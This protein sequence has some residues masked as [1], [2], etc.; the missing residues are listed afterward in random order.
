M[1]GFIDTLSIPI[2]HTDDAAIETFIKAFYQN[3]IS[4]P[5]TTPAPCP[6][7]SFSRRLGQL[8]GQVT[9]STARSFQVP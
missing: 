9:C 8:V 5:L 2:D 7:E 6:C 1:T 4:I 3:L